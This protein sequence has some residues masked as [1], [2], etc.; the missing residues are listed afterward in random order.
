[1]TVGYFWKKLRPTL[2]YFAGQN[3]CV[4]QITTVR[5]KKGH[6][7]LSHMHKIVS[8]LFRL[9]VQHCTHA[10]DKT[11]SY[12]VTLYHT[13]TVLFVILFIKPLTWNDVL[14]CPSVIIMFNDIPFYFSEAESIVLWEKSLSDTSC[15]HENY[16]GTKLSCV[17]NLIPWTQKIVFLHK[18]NIS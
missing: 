10:Q 18:H 5:T 13:W 1:M 3:E 14:F 15:S 17:R 8:A 12:R 4:S 2:K 9:C 6:T 16:A 11:E 7:R